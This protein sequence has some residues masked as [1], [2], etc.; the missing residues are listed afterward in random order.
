MFAQYGDRHDPRSPMDLDFAHHLQMTA[1]DE[2]TY[3]AFDGHRAIGSGPINEIALKVKAAVD[4]G[5]EGPVLI[6]DDQTSQPLELDLRGTPAEVVRRLAQGA[7]AGPEDAVRASRPG[8]GR[9][10]LGVVAREVTLLPRHWEWLSGQP[11]GA[12]VT[13]RKRVDSARISGTSRDRVRLAQD[14]AYR[15]L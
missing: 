1:P 6:F 12:S 7:D 11:G 5:A 4:H 8:P 2:S 10:R 15:V 9:P 3:T 14:S 13:M